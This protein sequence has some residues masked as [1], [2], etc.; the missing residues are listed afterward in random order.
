MIAAIVKPGIPAPIFVAGIKY[1]S[2]YEASMELGVSYT[3]THKAI[4]KSNYEPCKIR[5]NIVVL[6]SW[7]MLR[8][9]NLRLEGI[10]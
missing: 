5:K 9:D 7:V 8:V 6:E 2:I 3:A 1:P 4:K 10:A